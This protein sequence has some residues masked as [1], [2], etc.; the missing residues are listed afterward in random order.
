MEKQL[1]M[2]VC[3]ALWPCGLA[4]RRV[5]LFACYAPG[6][7]LLFDKCAPDTRHVGINEIMSGRV[8]S[9]ARIGHHRNIGDHKPEM[10]DYSFLTRSYHE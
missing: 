7:A 1:V 4:L 10:E 3:T 5:C 8:W 9:Q 6:L 2:R